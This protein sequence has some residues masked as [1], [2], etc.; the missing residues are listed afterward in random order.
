MTAS[1]PTSV[2]WEPPFGRAFSRSFRF[3]EWLGAPV[4]TLFE[5][6]LLTRLEVSLHLQQE[7]RIGIV[8]PRP[9]HVVLNGWYFYRLDFLPVS[10]SAIA[11]SLPRLV[12]HLLRD[13]RRV[14]VVFG[15]FAGRG[16]G[17]YE[18]EWNDELLPRYLAAV[19]NATDAVERLPL[20]D[21][22]GLIDGLADLAGEVF[23]SVTVVSG[24]GYKTEMNLAMFVRRNLPGFG[25]HLPLLAGLHEPETGDDGHA[26]ESLDWSVPTLGERGLT[27]APVNAARRAALEA[28]RRETESRARE[29]LGNRKRALADFER[30]LAEAQRGVMNREAQIAHFSRPWPVF[31]RALARLGMTLAV[32]GVI[33]AAADIHELHRDELE[34]ALAARQSGRALDLRSTV[35]ARRAARVRAARV[36]PPLFAGR[37]PFLVRKLIAEGPTWLA[38]TGTPGR[39]ELVRGSPASAGSATGPARI[40]HDLSEAARVLPGDILVAPVTSPA[41]TPLFGRIGGVVTDVG[42]ALA[43]ASIVA[44][45]YGIPAVVGCPHATTSIVDGQLVTIDGAAGVVYAASANGEAERVE[46]G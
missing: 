22:P 24:F 32:G 30:L 12:P 31:R 13:A 4:T 14:A 8:A 15:P 25:S 9:H 20:S 10:V 34:A 6:W 33:D 35:T 36:D 23:A 42:S 46:A 37:L 17:L 11:R 1:N 2:S 45:E 38:T 43:H 39:R 28:D 40:I 7:T 16:I 26:I 3:G 27:R 21:L 29:M 19:R 5:S 18:A 41:W 44:R